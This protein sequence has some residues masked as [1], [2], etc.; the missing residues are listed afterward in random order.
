MVIFFSRKFLNVN[1][2]IYCS[3]KE[4]FID[5]VDKSV[6]L[7]NSICSCYFSLLFSLDDNV[8]I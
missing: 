1:L 7:N 2:Q 6:F 5:I 4:K 3:Y 8:G